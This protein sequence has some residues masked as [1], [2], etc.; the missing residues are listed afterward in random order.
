MKALVLDDEKDVANFV[1]EM[2]RDKDIDTDV[3][4]SY[5]EAL[6]LC[7]NLYD[8]LF[9][10]YFLENGKKG[11]DFV[12]EYKQE[13][14]NC[15]VTIFTG[16]EDKIP[17][18]DR[19]LNKTVGYNK[20]ESCINT[21]IEKVN[22]RESNMRTNNDDT[23]TIEAK[24]YAHVCT[25][26]CKEMWDQ[27]YLKKDDFNTYLTNKTEEERKTRQWLINVFVGLGLTLLS[28]FATILIMWGRYQENV[29]QIAYIARPIAEKVQS[30][31][32]DIAIIKAREERQPKG[33]DTLWI[34]K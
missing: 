17:E 20:I 21:V 14:R 9:I 27:R 29:N 1:G 6:S 23:E 11:T 8:I 24:I 3:V 12:K 5:E 16:K 32:V 34:R 15:D 10:D 25:K 33:V 30:M 2:L 31:A 7:R 22:N 18:I 28:L 26:E 4:Y 19:L 13:H